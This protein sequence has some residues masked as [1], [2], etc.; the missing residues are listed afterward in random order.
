MLT[1]PEL[2]AGLLYCPAGTHGENEEWVTAFSFDQ[3]E[4][5]WL[6]GKP[7]PADG[8]GLGELPGNPDVMVC[9]YVLRFNLGNPCGCTHLEKEAG[10]AIVSDLLFFGRSRSVNKH[11]KIYNVVFGDGRARFCRDKEGRIERACSGVAPGEIER[12][13]DEVVFRHYFDPVYAD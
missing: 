8:D 3:D 6:T 9:S 12:V 4:S 11:Q 10:S 7:G 1:R 5:F 13:V 2:E